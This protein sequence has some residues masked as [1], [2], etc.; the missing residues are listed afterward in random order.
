MCVLTS[1]LVLCVTPPFPHVP[2][3]V[4]PQ[5]PLKALRVALDPS[6]IHPIDV[7]RVNNKGVFVNIAVAGGVSEVS[8][9]ELSSKW[10]RLLG[11]VAIG[12]HGKWH[13]PC[14]LG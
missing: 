11:P 1:H 8:A 9:E 3:L 12:F 6:N 5:D 13:R 14:A 2:P 7:G 4:P 10:K